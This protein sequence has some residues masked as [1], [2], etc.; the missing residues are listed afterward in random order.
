MLT[1]RQQKKL[2][3]DLTKGIT[4]QVIK[5][6]TTGKIPPTWNGFEL[7]TYLSEKF[8]QAAKQVPMDQKRKRAYNNTIAI[9]S[10]L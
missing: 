3:K 9:T 4:D 2:V 8:A 6:I 1:R 5:L 10:E 7:R